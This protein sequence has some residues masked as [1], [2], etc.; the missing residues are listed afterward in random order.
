MKFNLERHFLKLNTL[1]LKYNVMTDPR[2]GAGG[3][4]RMAFT[5]NIEIKYNI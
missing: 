3:G 1:I 5:M 4:F 2:K